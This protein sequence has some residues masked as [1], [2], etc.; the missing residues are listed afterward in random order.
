MDVA[1]RREFLLNDRSVMLPVFIE[2]NSI[3]TAMLK[4][5]IS[6]A[7]M[8]SGNSM[9]GHYR[10]AVYARQ[11]WLVKMTINHHNLTRPFLHG[12]IKAY[13]ISGS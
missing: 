10:G 13:H 6:G 11:T 3:R 4:Y 7:V 5:M 12:S 2:A 1:D 8:Y 9:Q